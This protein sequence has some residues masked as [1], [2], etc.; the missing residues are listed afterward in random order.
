MAKQVRCKRCSA[1]TPVEEGA[2]SVRCSGCGTTMRLKPAAALPP[3]DDDFGSPP[4]M[5]LPPRSKPAGSKPA[6]PAGSKPS[7]G[8]PQAGKASGKKAAAGIPTG[9][10]FDSKTLLVA[11]GGALLGLCLLV[12]G[13]VWAFSGGGDGG[14]GNG[15]AETAAATELRSRETLWRV[16]SCLGG[17]KARCTHSTRRSKCRRSRRASFPNRRSLRRPPNRCQSGRVSP[18]FEWKLKPTRLAVPTRGRSSKARC[19]WAHR[20][21]LLPENGPFVVRNL[22]EKPDPVPVVD[23][24]TGTAGDGFPLAALV[25][26]AVSHLHNVRLSPDGR[27]LARP[28]VTVPHIFQDVKNN[29]PTPD[30]RALIKI[31]TAGA[32]GPEFTLDAKAPPLWFDWIDAE[33]LAVVTNEPEAKLSIYDPAGK[34]L[35]ETAL[36]SQHLEFYNPYAG[37]GTPGWRGA[38]MGRLVRVD[39]CWLWE[40]ARTFCSAT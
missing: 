36:P 21:C 22:E 32:A 12:G 4:P 9:L 13:L 37:R 35:V 15:N 7:G 10:P 34:L 25:D 24:R 20:F 38:G 3:E 26:P 19:R 31:W 18:S 30:P 8:K 1:T 16:E 33:R 23:V 17:F 40:P 29:G 2:E 27:H 14:R 39:G 11:G 6:K 28:A 5:M